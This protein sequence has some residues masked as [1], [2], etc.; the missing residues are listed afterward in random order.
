[1]GSSSSPKSFWMGFLKGLELTSV[2]GSQLIKL[3][4]RLLC[5]TRNHVS[6][7]VQK[8]SG[9]LLFSIRYLLVRQYYEKVVPEVVAS[10]PFSS[11][12][13]L[14]FISSLC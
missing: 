1:M 9:T 12:S 10:F 14:I 4:N 13:F 7:V 11:L 3:D 6:A 2:E 5:S 8:I